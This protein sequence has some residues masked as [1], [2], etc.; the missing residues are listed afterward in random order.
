VDPFV[1]DTTVSYSGPE[2]IAK[3]EGTAT[4]TVKSKVGSEKI[5]VTVVPKLKLKVSETK[6][7]ETEGGYNFSFKI[8]N[9]SKEVIRVGGPAYVGV[10]RGHHQALTNEEEKNLRKGESATYTF[11]VP[12]AHDDECTDDF[13]SDI[14]VQYKGNSILAFINEDGTVEPGMFMGKMPMSATVNEGYL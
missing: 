1:W 6:R 12:S 2:I 4:I 10:Y 11:F 9:N 5:K 3:K 13:V 7:V 8:T 14:V